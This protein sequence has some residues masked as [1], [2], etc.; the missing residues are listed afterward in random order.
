MVCLMWLDLEGEVDEIEMCVGTFVVH[1]EVDSWVVYYDLDVDECYGDERNS[2]IEINRDENIER[3]REW[4][5]IHL[6][7]MKWV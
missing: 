4:S 1:G 7:E 6:G 3:K 2:A 5:L